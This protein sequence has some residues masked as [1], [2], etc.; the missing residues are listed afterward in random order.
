MSAGY[1]GTPLLKKLGV[2]P[3]LRALLVAVPG[4]V[5]E[6]GAFDGF[7]ARV[8]A[9]SL[10]ARGLAAACARGPFDYIH[11]FETERAPLEAGIGLLR[12]ALVANGMIWVSWPKKAS[13]VATSLTEDVI[14]ALALA[15]GLVDVKVCAVDAVWSGLRLVIPVADRAAM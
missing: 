13:K 5:A 8:E 7:S 10:A 15:S 2:K 6:I 3:G 11:V 9:P 1:S 14:R 12:R 4:S